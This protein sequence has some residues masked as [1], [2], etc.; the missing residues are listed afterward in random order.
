MFPLRNHFLIEN[1]LKNKANGKKSSHNVPTEHFDQFSKEIS[2]MLDLGRKAIVSNF[3]C[4][5]H[6]ENTKIAKDKCYITLSRK[7]KIYHSV[8]DSF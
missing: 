7:A 5:F 1:G 6:I 3:S 8:K 2:D 4:I